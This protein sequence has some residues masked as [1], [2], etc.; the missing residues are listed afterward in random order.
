MKILHVASEVFPLVKTGGLADITAALL[1]AL[2]ERGID[3][4]LLLPGFPSIREGVRQQ[5]K[6]AELGPAFGAATI[7]IRQGRMPE[8]GVQAYVIDAP[9]L[10]ARDGNPYMGPDGTDWPDNPRRFALLGWVAAHLGFGEFDPFW[11]PDLLHA[12]DWHAALSMAY[13]SAHPANKLR[14][15]FTVHNLAYQGLF[16]LEQ[17]RELDLPVAQMGHNGLEFHGQ[18]SFMKAGL[19][20]ADRVTTVSPRYALEICTPAFGCG[21]EG[22]LAARGNT[23][24]GILN[25]VD[26][27]QWDPT[28]DRHLE[29]LYSSRS[30]GGKTQCKAALQK[31]LNLAVDPHAPLF[32]VVSRL[33]DQKGMDLVLGSLPHL[34]GLG[35]QLALLGSGDRRLEQAFEEAARAHPSQIAVRI[36]YDEALAHRFVAGADVIMV[37]SRFE[38]CGLTQMYGLRYG[39]LPLVRRVGGLADTVVDTNR[40]NL[41]SES[42]TGFCFGPATVDALNEAISRASSTYADQE[43][44]QTLMKRGMAKDFS[45]ESSSKRYL[46]LYREMLGAQNQAGGSGT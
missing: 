33:T 25:G 39:T 13:L 6:I 5:K 18:G 11:T 8:T 37:P 19:L 32:T 16:P 2:N 46:S 14:T 24:S 7:T 1:P 45:W 3:A 36:A 44:W 23:L 35:G 10:Y 28:T 43:T 17:H 4:R 20:W 40:E 34:L 27:R 38:P 42:A 31:S 21:L 41:Q 29:K 12:H 26:Y 9:W 30:L 15:V 22:L